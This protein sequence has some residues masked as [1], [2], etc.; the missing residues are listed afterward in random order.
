MRRVGGRPGFPMSP[1][2]SY[3]GEDSFPEYTT[4]K[5]RLAITLISPFSTYYFSMSTCEHRQGISIGYVPYIYA[6]YRETDP[7]CAGRVRGSLPS[8]PVERSAPARCRARLPGLAFSC[9]LTSWL[10][11]PSRTGD[12]TDPHGDS[13]RRKATR[14]DAVESAA[15]AEGTNDSRDIDT[16]N[17]E[18]AKATQQKDEDA[19][20]TAR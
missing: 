10:A 6:I 8:S 3:G 16:G 5:M 18:P 1:P 12:S 20:S 19:D 4:H 15:P 14:T 7:Y 13:D 2:G 17:T 11:V 9:S